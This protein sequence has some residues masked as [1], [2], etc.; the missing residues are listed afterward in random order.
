MAEVKFVKELPPRAR[1][2]RPE[3]AWKA[4]LRKKPGQWA[5]L[6]T[7]SHKSIGTY[8]SHYHDFEFAARGGVAYGRYIGEAKP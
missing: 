8:R 7:V 4:E 2:D 1:P 6:T 5:E 3:A